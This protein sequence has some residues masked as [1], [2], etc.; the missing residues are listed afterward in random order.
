MATVL[1]KAF[2]SIISAIAYCCFR[3]QDNHKFNRFN[4]LNY[5]MPRGRPLSLQVRFPNK[6][7]VFDIL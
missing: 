5:N 6:S 7:F 2:G 4:N 1:K 3:Y